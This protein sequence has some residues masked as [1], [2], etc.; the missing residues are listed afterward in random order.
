[1]IG[2]NDNGYSTY[3]QAIGVGD[4]GLLKWSK[5]KESGK[6]MFLTIKAF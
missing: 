6:T 3:W 5:V 4:R 1:M 2:H